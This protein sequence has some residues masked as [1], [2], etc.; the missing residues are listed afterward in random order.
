M[1]KGFYV[2]LAANNIRKNGKLYI[3]YLF[4]CVLSVVMFYVM[5]SLSLDPAVKKMFAKKEVIV[6]GRQMKLLR[7]LQKITPDFI[8]CKIAYHIQKRKIY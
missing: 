1:K 7:P 4:T 2:R 3:P 8:L 6:P 5:M